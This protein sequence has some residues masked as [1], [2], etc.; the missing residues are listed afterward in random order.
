[1]MTR[2]MFDPQMMLLSTFLQAVLAQLEADSTS[3]KAWAE[4]AALV[5]TAGEEED[6]ERINPRLT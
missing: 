6:S 4:A 2:A 3:A 5:K 1:M